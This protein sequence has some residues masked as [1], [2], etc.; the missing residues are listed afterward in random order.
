MPGTLRKH[1]P[2]TIY[3]AN[4]VL[5]KYVYLAFTQVVQLVFTFALSELHHKLH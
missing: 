4:V 1:P 5:A 3:N 2:T